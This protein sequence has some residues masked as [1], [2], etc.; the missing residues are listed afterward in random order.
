MS[1]GM[2]RKRVSKEDSVTIHKSDHFR[3]AACNA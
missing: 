2:R 1:R 3:W